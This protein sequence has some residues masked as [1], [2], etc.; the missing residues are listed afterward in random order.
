MAGHF[1]IDENLIPSL[2]GK[3]AIVT[4]GSSGIGLSTSLLLSHKGCTKV[5]IFDLVEPECP[6]PP[7]VHFLRV[8]VSKW[9]QLRAAFDSI[10]HVDIA[11]ANAG[12]QEESS[13][14]V[15]TYDEKGRLKAPDCKEVIDTNI[16]G[17]LSFVKL[18]WSAMRRSR[19]V[20]GGSIVITTGMEGYLGSGMGCVYAASKAAL[21]GLVRSLRSIMPQDGITINA[22][23]PGPTVTGKI[24]PQHLAT[25]LLKLGVPVN[26]ADAVAL[27]MV[28]S[29]TARQ[30]RRVEAYGKEKEGDI[31]QAAVGMERWN[32]RIIMV[33][34]ETYVEVEESLSDL[35]PFW[36]GRE[37][38][39]WVRMGQAACDFRPFPAE[40]AGEGTGGRRYEYPSWGD[41]GRVV[42]AGDLY[43]A[44]VDEV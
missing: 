23:A 8:D 9:E 40:G 2:E 13:F 38:L 44:A 22:V 28:Y 30:K 34:G 7:S 18:A 17:T 31:Y 25:P 36:M 10:T 21:I 37:N 11:F 20:E 1:Q 12:V 6:L 16:R 4:G 27:A 42:F 24:F 14:F 41:E 15:D 39:G 43:S 35:R 3:T 29:A 19:S 32:G 26:S 33:Q 5:F